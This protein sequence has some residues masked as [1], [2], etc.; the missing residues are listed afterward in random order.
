[1][2]KTKSGFAAMIGRPNTGKSTLMNHL[3]G[4]KIAITSD[5]P[6]T[7][8]N[9]IQTVYTD[10][11]GQ[12]IFV[13]TP[14][15]L[16][17][18]HNRLGEYMMDVSVGTLADA[19]VVLWLV[20]PSSYIGEGDREIAEALRKVTTPVILVINKTD[21]IRKDQVL[22]IMDSWKD[23]YPFAEIV[24]VSGLM[25]KN[26]DDLMDTI[27]RYLPAGPLLYDEE[28]LTD[29]PVR[30]IAAEIIREKAL[31]CL[32]EE[33]P[34]GIAVTVEKYT[35]R[36]DGVTE[37][38]ASVICEKN[39]HKGIVIGRGGAMLKRIGTLARREIEELAGGQVFLKLFV[40]VR[41]DWRDNEL[42]LK[43]YGYYKKKES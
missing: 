2:E 37:I 15:F 28:T 32:K 25:E 36:P 16:R 24:P 21:T 31:L 40:K 35:L 23:L 12:I 38:Q 39:S 41:K 27:F 13:D 10:E 42:L 22:G 33:V 30:E 4:Q 20:E 5:R 11:R 1:M 14:G 34:H 43:N 9:R 18:S 29:Q 19:D 7:T 26:L 8:R 3:I 6:Q 17:K